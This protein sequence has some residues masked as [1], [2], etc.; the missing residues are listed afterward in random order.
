MTKSELRRYVEAYEP[1]FDGWSKR[2]GE[3]FFRFSGPFVQQVWFEN[4]RSGAYRPVMTV[5]ILVASGGARL[6]QFL[7]IQ[8]REVL[9][10]DHERKQDNVR[11]AMLAEF[12]PQIS[13]PLDESETMQLFIDQATDRIIDASSLASLYAYVGNLSKAKE[14]IARVRQLATSKSELL[15]WERDRVQDV[16][17]LADAIEKGSEVA[18]LAANRETEILRFTS[19]AK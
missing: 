9:P 7:D 5:S 2:D 15:D 10:R 16:E 3:G 4:L 13:K 18:Y 8:N 11:H 12:R 14:L 17:S 1:L 6:H 19:N